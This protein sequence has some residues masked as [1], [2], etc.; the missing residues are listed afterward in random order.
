MA[1][2]LVTKEPT[3]ISLDKGNSLPSDYH[4]C[5]VFKQNL[6]GDDFKANRIRRQLSHDG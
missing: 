3:L 4:P 6:G 5:P 2:K 1:S